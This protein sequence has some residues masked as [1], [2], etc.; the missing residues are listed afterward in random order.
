M[1][2]SIQGMVVTLQADAAVDEFRAVKVG[3][4]DFSAAVAV[5]GAAPIVGITLFGAGA[6]EQTSVQVTGVA[7]AKA[8]GVVTRGALV[9]AGAA[10]VLVASVAGDH[11]VGVALTGA[12]ASG[13]EFSVLLSSYKTYTA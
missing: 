7:R 2:E 1:S 12:A 9:T 8:G 10:G 11:S 3:A 13:D 5:D 4:A 6:G